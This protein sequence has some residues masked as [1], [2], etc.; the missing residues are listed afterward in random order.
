M[1]IIINSPNLYIHLHDAVLLVQFIIDGFI[2][3]TSNTPSILYYQCEN[4]PYMGSYI[5]VI[6]SEK[7]CATLKPL[8]NNSLVTL[9]IKEDSFNDHVGN[10]ISLRLKP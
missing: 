6:Y 10:K 7:Y 5:R 8:V 2:E 4:H 3:I 1:E 9:Y